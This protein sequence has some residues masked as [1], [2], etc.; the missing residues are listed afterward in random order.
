MKAS[1]KKRLQASG[2]VVGTTRDFL[3]LSEQ[4]SASI[5]IKLRA[6]LLSKRRSRGVVP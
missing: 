4:E 3:N 6:T 5:E 1:R 2:W